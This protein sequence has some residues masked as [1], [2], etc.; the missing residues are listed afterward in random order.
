MLMTMVV[1][2]SSQTKSNNIE[3]S[4]PTTDFN[5]RHYRLQT[6][7]LVDYRLQTTDYRLQTTDNDDERYKVD[8]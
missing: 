4:R 8:C 7:I 1:H 2:V 5:D 3:K 6:T